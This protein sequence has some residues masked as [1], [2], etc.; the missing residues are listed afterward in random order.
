MSRYPGHNGLHYERI[1]KREYRTTCDHH[2]QTHIYRSEPAVD[3][4][5]GIRLHM[6]GWLEIQAGYVWDGPSGPAIHTGDFM[7]GSLYHDAL[8]DLMKSHHLPILF[9]EAADKLLMEVCEEDGMPGPRAA[10]VYAAVRAFGEAYM[11][12]HE[13][14]AQK[15]E[16]RDR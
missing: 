8:Y 15:R 14:A 9:R 7:R 10:W 13:S 5:A 11:R 2:V 16:R 12:R 1:G 4:Q 3:P 6:D